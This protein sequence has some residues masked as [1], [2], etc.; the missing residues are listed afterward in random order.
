MNR[1]DGLFRFVASAFRKYSRDPESRA[2][3]TRHM[4]QSSLALCAEHNDL[5]EVALI[6]AETLAEL[7]RQDRLTERSVG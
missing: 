2:Y 5:G 7:K 1:T 4:V 3:S 6:C